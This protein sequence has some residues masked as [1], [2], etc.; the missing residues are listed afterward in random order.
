M[1]ARSAYHH[2]DL[3]AA[4]LDAALEMLAEDPSAGP[5]LRA[6]AERVGVAH[7]AL[8][9]HFADRDALLAALAARG[10]DRLADAL[11]EAAQPAAFLTAY[12]RFALA[13]P[14]L[15]AVMTQRRYDEINAHPA[16]RASIDRVIAVALRV[17]ATPG[18]DEDTRRREVMRVWMLAHGGI[19]LQR[20]G[21][22]RLRSDAEFVAEILLVAGLGPNE[23]DAR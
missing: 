7:R 16:L 5:S 13:Q 2:G 19:G 1:T 8:Y 11:A 10:F 17:L 12:V 6:L 21:M 22:L 9:N 23:D 20:S 14:G 15:Y 3:A 4:A 18:A